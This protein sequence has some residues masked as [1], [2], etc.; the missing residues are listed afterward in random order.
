MQGG[1]I[2]FTDAPV[3]EVHAA[4][5]EAAAGRNV[6]VVG[7]GELVGQFLDHDLLDEII[8]SVDPGAARRRL[9]AAA[10][11][12]HRRRCGCSRRPPRRRAPSCTCTTRCA[13]AGG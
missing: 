4:M 8:V 12:A 7:G 11:P 5:V 10:A 6:W 9:P 2:S 3:P 13:E 1:E